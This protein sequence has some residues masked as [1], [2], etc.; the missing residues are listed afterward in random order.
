[1]STVTRPLLDVAGLTMR[2]GGVTAIDALSFV[3][4]PRQITSMIGPNGAGK[5]TLF[6]CL[7]GF[8]RPTSGT[9]TL[10]HPARGP[11]RLDRLPSHDMARSAQV[12]RTFQNI[13]L[14]PGMSVLENLIVAQH[15]TLQA[16][17]VFSLAGL[18]G[19]ARY[20]DA[21]ARALDT[22]HDLLRRFDLE[23]VADTPAGA[24]AYGVQ[25]RVEIARAM[26]GGPRLLC[27]DEPAAG[28]NPR[29]SASLNELLTSLIAVEGI[30]VLLVEHDMS[31][32]MR[33][34]QKVVVLNHGRKI[35]EGTPEQVQCHPQVISA[36]LGEPDE[37]AE[38]TLQE[39]YAP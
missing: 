35:A 4:Q 34:S 7:T 5:T 30:A 37:P 33:V 32:V 20:R 31:V 28:L 1:M 29:E 2:F 3:A 39:E 18:L 27:L 14:F 13:R 12:L 23:R 24:L 9:I 11:L 8:Y 26:A 6:N 36:Y 22:A 19:L 17:S 16:A 21:E 15:N 38:A 25:R 10:H